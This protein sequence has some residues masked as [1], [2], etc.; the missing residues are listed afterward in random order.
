MSY[1]AQLL[2]DLAQARVIR[3]ALA[4]YVRRS[5][6][7]EDDRDAGWAVLAKLTQDMRRKS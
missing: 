5:D 6:I 1:V 3:D 7:S 2:P 4:D